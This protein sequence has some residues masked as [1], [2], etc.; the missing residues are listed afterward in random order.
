VR[1]KRAAKSAPGSGLLKTKRLFSL[2]RRRTRDAAVSRDDV[3]M[4][5]SRHGDD[6]VARIGSKLCAGRDP[7]RILSYE[8]G[9]SISLV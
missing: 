9:C 2:G 3:T 5:K 4:T 8:A 7:D 6:P 1:A